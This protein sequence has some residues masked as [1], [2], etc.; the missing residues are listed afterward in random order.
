MFRFWIWLKS[1][2]NKAW[3]TPAVAVLGAV[4]LALGAHAFGPWLEGRL[5]PNIQADTVNGLLSVIAASMLSVATFSLGIMVS[6]TASASGNAT[7]RATELVM[8]DH[9]TRRAIG[10]FIAA[11]IYAVVAKIALDLG[12]YRGAGL[13]VLF[14]ATL[15]VLTY[16]VVSLVMWVQTLSTLGRLPDT[17]A[18]IETAAWRP[19]AEHARDPWMGA[20]AGPLHRPDGHRVTANSVGYLTHINLDALQSLGEELQAEVHVRVRP[21]SLL[22]TS[23]ELVCLETTG[24]S[25]AEPS[26]EQR[27]TLREAFVWGKARTY[28]QDPR[29]GL[30]VLS[31]VAQRA[32]SPAVN[33]P[34]TAVQ[35]MSIAARLLIKAQR[36]RANNTGA[37]RKSHNRVSLVALDEADFV[38]DCFDPIS[39][40][41]GNNTDVAVRIQ[42]VLHAV[43][44][45]GLASVRQ[46]AQ[47]QAATS[48]E[49]GL[50]SS[51]LHSDRLRLTQVHRQLFNT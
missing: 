25:A 30:I 34:G 27:Q 36:A 26:E 45:D 16:L 51:Q 21:G 50:L 3:F 1:Q 12:Y 40:D 41:A 17:L 33:D 6:A 13:F 20:R 43:A 14:M 9:G 8:S 7:P 32:L 10:S 39:R 4:L 22:S 5:V 18:K 47:A 2:R 46:A 19:L 11:F 31:E 44:T 15:G 37:E 29:F 24:T 28:D 49:R 38:R 35:V 48:L 42:K 23:T